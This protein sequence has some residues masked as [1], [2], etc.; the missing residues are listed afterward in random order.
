[1]HQS[2]HIIYPKV[3]GWIAQH[4]LVFRD[5]R[6]WFDGEPLDEP[7]VEEFRAFTAV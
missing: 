7:M 6:A 2:E 4:R 3:I 5:G 1:V